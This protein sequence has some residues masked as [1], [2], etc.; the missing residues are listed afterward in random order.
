MVSRREFGA[1]VGVAAKSSM[2]PRIRFVQPARA[3][4]DVVLV[5]GLYAD[6]STGSSRSPDRHGYDD[7]RL[8][9]RR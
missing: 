7:T 2:A 5:H 6:G 4:K 1:M 3:V 9:P 8:A